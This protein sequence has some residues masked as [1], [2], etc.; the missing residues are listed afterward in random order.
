MRL[1]K[2]NFSSMKIS[3]NFVKVTCSK[4]MLLKVTLMLL[5]LSW[6]L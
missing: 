1:V 5:C 6:A 3:K 2:D 4:E